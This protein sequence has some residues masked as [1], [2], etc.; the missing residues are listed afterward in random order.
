MCKYCQQYGDGHKWYLN[1]KNFSEE[2]LNSARVVEAK[3]IE[4]LGGPSKMDF[5]IGA[6]TMMDPLIPDFDDHENLENVSKQVEKL[7]GGQVVPLED[8]LKI[9]DL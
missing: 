8:A 9:I 6:A 3:I 2:T 1:P 7:H 5:E 4:Y